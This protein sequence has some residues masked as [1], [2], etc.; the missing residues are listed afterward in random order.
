MTCATFQRQAEIAKSN[1][2]PWNFVYALF[3][4]ANQTN[5]ALPLSWMK[6]HG[7]DER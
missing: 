3:D 4:G 5:F 2:V 7:V 1:G 6:A